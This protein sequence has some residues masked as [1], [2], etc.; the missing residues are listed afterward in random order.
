MKTLFH[1]QQ[2]STSK[3][4]KSQ[5]TSTVEAQKKCQSIETSTTEQQIILK[6]LR[7]PQINDI[8]KD[9]NRHCNKV[10]RI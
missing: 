2:I 4:D 1:K 9:I 10:G 8:M 6:I 5:A 7:T 3:V